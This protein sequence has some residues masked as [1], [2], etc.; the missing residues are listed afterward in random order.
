[1]QPVG[2]SA[3][4][5]VNWRVCQAWMVALAGVSDSGLGGGA[6]E[7]MGV[8]PETAAADASEAVQPPRSKSGANKSGA[9]KG[10]GEYA[11]V[12]RDARKA[13]MRVR[14]ERGK[15]GERSGDAA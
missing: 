7:E 3:P 14:G 8:G 2:L 10:A 13:R 6:G 12:S 11:A 5:S 15:A 1:M 9:S 4:V